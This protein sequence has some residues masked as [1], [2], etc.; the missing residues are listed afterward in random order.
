MNT[1]IN[2]EIETLKFENLIWIIFAFLA[3]LNIYGDVCEE[4]YLTNHSIYFKQKA[5]D[6]FRIT[7]VASLIIYMYF[8]SKNFNL[9]KQAT[10]D[11]IVLCRLKAFGS[12]LFII[13]TILLIY[14]QRKETSFIGTSD[15]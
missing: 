2:K 14:V 7:I 1:S 6:I 8:F 3:I 12:L 4:N 10:A 11:N 9:Y 15:V 5:N 13:A